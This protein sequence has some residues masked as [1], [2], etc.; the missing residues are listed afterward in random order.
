MDL[1]YWVLLTWS[2]NCG[3]DRSQFM[4]GSFYSFPDVV[5]YLFETSRLSKICTGKVL[6]GVDIGGLRSPLI[7]H[8]DSTECCA[9][10]LYFRLFFRGFGLPL[11]PLF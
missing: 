3:D 4:Y 9:W 7:L 2:L 1:L 6:S 11:G 5:E 8:G 10:V